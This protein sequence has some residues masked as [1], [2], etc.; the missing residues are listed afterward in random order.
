MI[1]LIIVY[2]MCGSYKNIYCNTFIA[3]ELN[4]MNILSMFKTQIDNRIFWDNLDVNHYIE[5]YLSYYFQIQKFLSKLI[6]RRK[7]FPSLYICDI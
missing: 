2:F 1:T 7:Y 4:P 3:L 6:S 5:Y